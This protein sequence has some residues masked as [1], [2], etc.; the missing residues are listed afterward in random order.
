MNPDA[1][2]RCP[3]CKKPVARGTKEF[4]FC[5]ERCRWL[6]LGNWL[7]GGYRIPAGAADLAGESPDEADAGSRGPPAAED[8]DGG[9]SGPSR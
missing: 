6:D 1:A 7:T 4:P 5:S 2:H 9:E 8:D 3:I